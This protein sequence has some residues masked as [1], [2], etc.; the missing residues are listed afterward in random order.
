MLLIHLILRVPY[1]WLGRKYFGEK[2]GHWPERFSD[3]SWVW[4]PAPP[5]ELCS[6]A[7]N[8]LTCRQP[9]Q[10]PPGGAK[11]HEWWRGLG[12]KVRRTPCTLQHRIL[13][14]V[15]LQWGIDASSASISSFLNRFLIIH[16][17]SIN[18]LSASN[19]RKKNFLDQYYEAFFLIKINVRI[20]LK[21]AKIVK[22]QMT[23]SKAGRIESNK[24]YVPYKFFIIKV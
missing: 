18:F 4:P 13:T 3:M 24:G 15:C 21:I 23:I 19:E 17:N 12:W 8:F 14:Y 16:N 10:H 20:E 1:L 22:L 2:R 5:L 11:T 7:W 6:E 9:E